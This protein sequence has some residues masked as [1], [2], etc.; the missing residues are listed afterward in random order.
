MKT[1]TLLSVFREVIGSTPQ[2]ALWKIYALVLGIAANALEQVLL[3]MVLFVGMIVGD[4]V[5]GTFLA[6]RDG[7]EIKPFRWITGPMLKLVVV[8]I[9]LGIMSGLDALVL[10]TPLNHMLESPFVIG[11]ALASAF[12]VSGEA[13]GKVEKLTGWKLVSWFTDRIKVLTGGK[14]E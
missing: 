3:P 9:F 11:G 14:P 12:A 2:E 13:V 8:F 5:L 10:Q 4:A 6:I 7:K 1:K